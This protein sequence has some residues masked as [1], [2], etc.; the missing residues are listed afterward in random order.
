MK[1]FTSLALAA[2]A[3]ICL[4]VAAP[5]MQAQ[6]GVEIGVAVIFQHVVPEK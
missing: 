3:G 5:K 2:I 1:I 6:V 4:T